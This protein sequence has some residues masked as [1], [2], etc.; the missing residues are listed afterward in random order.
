M[1]ASEFDKRFEDGEDMA[2]RID[3]SKAT[4]LGPA[5]RHLGLDLPENELKLLDE[6]ARRQAMSPEDLVK[7]WI[8]ERLH[9][10]AA[11]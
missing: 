7:T 1:K 10:T 4:R 5:P 9:Q 8:I 6:E 11:E 2:D 3:W